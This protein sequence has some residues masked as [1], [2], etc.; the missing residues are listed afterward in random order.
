MLIQI[1]KIAKFEFKVT[2]HNT[3]YMGYGKKERKKKHP[4]TVVISMLKS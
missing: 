1:F 3:T 2:G 4:Q